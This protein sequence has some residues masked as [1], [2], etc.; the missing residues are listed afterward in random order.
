MEKCIAKDYK[1]IIFYKMTF[2]LYQQ[3]FNTTNKIHSSCNRI[4]KIKK[5]T[6]S[7]TKFRTQISRN[8]KISTT[9]FNDTIC[10]NCRY[11]NTR[12]KCLKQYK[13]KINIIQER[14]KLTHKQQRKSIK[15]VPPRPATPTH[16]ERR[17]NMVT[18]RMC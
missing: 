15:N 10:C 9:T 3:N 14:D 1:I 2:K 12:Q 7:T 18:P 8:H 13:L 11:T 16:Q 17:I 6:N 4:C 5:N